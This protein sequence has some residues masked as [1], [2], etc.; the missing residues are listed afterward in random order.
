MEY[1]LLAYMLTKEPNYSYDQMFVARFE[2]AQACN[3]ALI[4]KISVDTEENADYECRL[5]NSKGVIQP[6]EITGDVRIVTGYDGE[7]GVPNQI[8]EYRGLI[9]DNIRERVN[10]SI[11]LYPF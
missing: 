3:A 5:V 7:R 4:D 6:R 9:D 10:P 11:N 1:V 8:I 2:S